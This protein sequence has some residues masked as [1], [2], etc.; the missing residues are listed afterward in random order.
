[1]QALQGCRSCPEVLAGTLTHYRAMSYPPLRRLWDFCLLS[2]DH[3]MVISPPDG[4]FLGKVAKEETREGI[5]P[6]TFLPY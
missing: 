1:M 2:L 6:I 3:K 5:T 4:M